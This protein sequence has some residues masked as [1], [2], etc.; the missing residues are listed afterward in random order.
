[1]ET[2][3]TL[4]VTSASNWKG[5][6]GSPV[7]LPSGNTA[8]LRRPGIEH[9]LRTGSIPNSL[10]NLISDSLGANEKGKLTELLKDSEDLTELFNLM[11][12]VLV[13]VVIEPKVRKVPVDDDGNVIPIDDRDPNFIYPDEVDMED[14]TFIFQYATG[15]TK[16]LERFREE[17]REA[18][19]ALQSVE[20]VENPTE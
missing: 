7:E 19:G 14:K 11:D 20:D 18:L 10:R 1:M 17:Q 4:Q 5:R 16:S 8:L 6:R 13:E 3:E 12:R 2:Q 15:G 9:F